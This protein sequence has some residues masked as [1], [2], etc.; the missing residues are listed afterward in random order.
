MFFPVCLSDSLF[1]LFGA[2]CLNLKGSTVPAG[3]G[4]LMVALMAMSPL[5]LR[6][7]CA[8]SSAEPVLLM[9]SSMKLKDA[10]CGVPRL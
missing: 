1:L 5:V 6:Y 7:I 10:F 3:V 8:Q 9:Y 2:N 4:L